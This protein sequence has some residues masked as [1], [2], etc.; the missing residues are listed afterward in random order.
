MLIGT[1][2]DFHPPNAVVIDIAGY[3]N[4]F[5]EAEPK[6]GAIEET[7]QRRAVVAGFCYIGASSS[8]MPRVDTRRSLAVSTARETLNPVTFI[9]SGIFIVLVTMLACVVSV[10]KFLTMDP[11]VAFRG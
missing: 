10:G 1:L 4:I 7:G 6:V 9:G 3:T 8:G 2:D 11:A 5:P